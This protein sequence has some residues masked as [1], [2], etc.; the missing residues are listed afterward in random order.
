MYLISIYF[1]SNTNK[2]IQQYIDQVATK[3]GN[4]FMLDG[5]VPP[6]ITISAFESQ[7]EDA[8]VKAM[9]KCVYGLQ[10]EN[11]QWVSVGTFL[12]HV[13]F[14]QPVLNAYLHRLQ[15]R[16]YDTISSVK[17]AKISP[18]YQPFQWLAHTTIGKTLTQEQMK[19]AFEVLQNSFAPFAGQVIKIG[20][21]KTNPYTEIKNWDL[22][23]R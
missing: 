13:I 19:A 3:T 2:K 18:V 14:L 22:G 6:H 20:L 10:S 17:D 8:V 16:V 5:Q 15:E 12:P 21:A 23:E 7:S 9:E 4:P 1:D 11:I